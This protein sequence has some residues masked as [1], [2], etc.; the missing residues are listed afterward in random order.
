VQNLGDRTA[1]NFTL[2]IYD[3]LTTGGETE[4][5]LYQKPLAVLQPGQAETIELDWN[6]SL[7][8]QHRIYT[9]IRTTNEDRRVVNLFENSFYTIP[10]GTFTTGD[11]VVVQKQSHIIYDLPYV[12]KI[13]FDVNNS[14]VAPQYLSDW[15]I[16]PT[17]ALYA[18]RLK[19]NPTIKITLQGTIDPNSGETDPGLADQ[20]TNA[21]RDELYNL[22][23]GYEQMMVLPGL[24]LPRWRV[25]RNPE[26][27][28]WVFEERRRVDITTVA[29]DEK[30]LFKPLKTTYIKRQ[31]EPAI[32]KANISGIVPVRAGLMKLN[33]NELEDSASL[34]PV[35]SGAQLMGDYPLHLEQ[36]QS[37][38]AWLDQD[39]TYSIV[40]TDTL[41]REFKTRPKSTK[42]QAKIVGREWRYYVLAK[43]ESTMPFYEFYWTGLLDLVPFLTEEKN[44]RIRFEGHGCATGP[45]AVNDRLSKQRAR[46]FQNKFLQGVQTRYPQLYQNVKSRLDAPRGGGEAEPFEIRTEN[47]QPLLIGDNQQPLGR[48]LNR[49]VM[50]KIYSGD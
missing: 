36:L 24:M 1:Q 7:P 35:V 16:Q 31:N 50:I 10:K 2:E 5:L 4:Q 19:E 17:M 44:T 48:Q 49:R 15:T 26:D 40:L 8:G 23:V 39:V 32:F 6:T 37:P 38:S 22:G 18:K 45:E 11:T 30:I 41:N 27:A 29:R 25:P 46:D 3:S 20:R 13:F 33:T 21:V 12:G 47:G 42:L 34:L 14:V 43:F 28:R 9:K